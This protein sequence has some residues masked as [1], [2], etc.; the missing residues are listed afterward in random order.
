MAVQREKLKRFQE[1]HLESQVQ[2]GDQLKWVPKAGFVKE[3]A[4]VEIVLNLQALNEKLDRLVAQQQPD[5]LPG[6]ASA[7]ESNRPLPRS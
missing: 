6:E 7:L 3:W 4:L 5:T 2:C 1:Q